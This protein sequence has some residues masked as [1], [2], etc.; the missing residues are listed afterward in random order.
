M[1]GVSGGEQGAERRNRR[2]VPAQ[3][4]DAPSPR[5][6]PRLLARRAAVGP[7]QDRPAAPGACAWP[8]C[9]VS[10]ITGATPSSR[11]P[12]VA[13]VP[14]LQTRPTGSQPQTWTFCAWLVTMPSVFAGRLTAAAW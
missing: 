7:V 5:R 4:E 10:S 12:I 3:S 6:L 1:S 9:T 13:V 14:E 8:Y 2:L 11:V